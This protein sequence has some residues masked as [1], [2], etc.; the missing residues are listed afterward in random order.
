MCCLG[1]VLPRVFCFVCLLPFFV[2]VLQCRV[3]LTPA[4]TC[5]VSLP[6]FVY[7][8]RQFSFSPD[9]VY[10]PLLSCTV[11]YLFL[12]SWSCFLVC[13][14]AQSLLLCFCLPVLCYFL[15]FYSLLATL[16]W[17]TLSFQ[18]QSSCS[19]ISEYVHSGL[20]A[21]PTTR[22]SHHQ[23]SSDTTSHHGNQRENKVLLLHPTGVR[24]SD[25]YL[26]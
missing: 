7:F 23:W 20:S 9:A 14:C 15:C 3:L 1:F 22:K 2:C 19:I 5:H 4:L 16:R 8:S 12:V 10:W 13:L 24:S 17:E 25:T 11:L 6:S 21:C 26:W 18:F